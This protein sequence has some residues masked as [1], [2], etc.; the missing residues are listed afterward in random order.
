MTY[1]EFLSACRTLAKYENKSEFA[2][3]LGVKP[4][5]YIRAESGNRPPGRELLEEAAQ[6]AGFSLQDCLKIPVK[7]ST[8][9][10]DKEAINEFRRALSDHRRDVARG[11]VTTLRSMSSAKTG[12][13]RKER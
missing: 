7:V 3:K 8:P 9:T 10:E 13:K 5:T 2:R 4:G 1:S 6:L 11:V 12:K